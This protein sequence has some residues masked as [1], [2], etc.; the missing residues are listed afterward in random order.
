MIKVLSTD[1]FEVKEGLLVY[2]THYVLSNGELWDE[3]WNYHVYS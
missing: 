2:L 1:F 3:V